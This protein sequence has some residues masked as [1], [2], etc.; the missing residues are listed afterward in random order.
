ML[1]YQVSINQIPKIIITQNIMLG[2]LA[3]LAKQDLPQYLVIVFETQR[4]N[5]H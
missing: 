2:L 3:M 5:R 1:L 4:R